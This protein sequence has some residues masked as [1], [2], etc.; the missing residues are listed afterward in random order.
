MFK[1]SLFLLCLVVFL[2]VFSIQPAQG[3]SLSIAPDCNFPTTVPQTR[4]GSEGETTKVS[5]GINLLE[6]FQLD[7]IRGSFK[8]RFFVKL[9]WHD[10]RLA[11][12]LQKSSRSYCKIKIDD[13]W[14]PEPYVYNQRK[15]IREFDR[16]VSVNSKGTVTY[17]QIFDAEL[18]SP[19]DFTNFPFDTQHL[20]VKIISLSNQP[21]RVEFVENQEL[22]RVSDNLSLVGWSVGQAN[23]QTKVQHLELIQKTLPFFKFEL[24]IKRQSEFLFWKAVFPLLILISLINL[25]FWL[26]ISQIIARVS[27]SS[28]TMVSILAYE[29]NKPSYLPEVPYLLG[30]DIFLIGT[31][32]LIALALAESIITYKLFQKEQQSLALRID[33]S[34]RCFFPILVLGLLGFAFRF[35]FL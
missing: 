16:V 4:P 29:L 24:E 2:L 6:I 18:L 3:S 19:L 35:A 10:P 27:L 26:E 11:K 32:L 25:I 21:E 8:T 14:N 1:R 31:M 33:I 28:L 12:K 23:T 17:R 34:L 9:Q 15:L 20:M 22:N 30:K 7:D 5:I 13:I